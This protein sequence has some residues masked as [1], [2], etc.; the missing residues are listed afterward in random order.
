[1]TDDWAGTYKIIFW[2]NGAADRDS[3]QEVGPLEAGSAT[4]A[5]RQA[6]ALHPE[7]AETDYS[8]VTVSRKGDG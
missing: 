5:Y 8:P 1:M 4:E 3:F 2:T 7:F 6:V